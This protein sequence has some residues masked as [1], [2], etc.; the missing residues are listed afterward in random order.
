MNAACP[1]HSGR[2]DRRQLCR[3]V[4]TSRLCCR[5][6]PVPAQGWV[7]RGSLKRPLDEAVRMRPMRRPAP[8]NVG[9][10]CCSG[11]RIDRCSMEKRR[12]VKTP[13]S[14]S[15]QHPLSPFSMG[16][17]TQ[18]HAVE[19]AKQLGSCTRR[20]AGFLFFF[21]VFKNWSVFTG[22]TARVQRCRPQA[23]EAALL[24]LVPNII[25]GV[26]RGEQNG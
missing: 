21:A 1:G 16:Q 22:Q 5:V 9:E 6:L 15:S 7:A 25:T 24:V 13:D 4:L 10:A 11:R 8:A 14:G 20:A 18:F 12:G 19:A 2:A 23:L 26:L 17:K 3:S